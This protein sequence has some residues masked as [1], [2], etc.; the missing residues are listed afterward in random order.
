MISFTDQN[1]VQVLQHGEISHIKAI[2]EGISDPQLFQVGKLQAVAK[3]QLT[4]FDM[5][6]RKLTFGNIMSSSIVADYMAYKIS[7][8]LH[9]NF[10][11]PTVLRTVVYNEKVQQMALSLYIENTYKPY[12]NYKRSNKLIAFDYIISNYDR[13]FNNFLL[14]EIDG[15]TQ[16]IAID[17]GW[18]LRLFSFQEWKLYYYHKCIRKDADGDIYYTPTTHPDKFMLEAEIVDRLKHV[19][20]NSY[21]YYSLFKDTNITED[22]IIKSLQHIKEIYI[23]NT[24]NNI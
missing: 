19:L 15:Q 11:P 7:N 24:F 9:F 8:Y 10:V 6:Y 22:V 13:N 1:I 17:H 21:E 2:G 12:E 18:A 14:K 5:Y 20:G 16:E 4:L 3:P 23:V